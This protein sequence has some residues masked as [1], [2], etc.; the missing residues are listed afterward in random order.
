MGLIAPGA[1]ALVVA[2]TL[3]CGLASCGSSDDSQQR[4]DTREC[5]RLTFFH[6]G[7]ATEEHVARVGDV[8]RTSGG[9]SV[10]HRSPEEN[11]QVARERNEGP[12]TPDGRPLYETVTPEHTTGTWTADFGSRA[13]LDEALRRLG[14]AA[15]QTSMQP[16]D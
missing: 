13:Q 5:L 2:A 9:R 12:R 3:A 6:E 15:S 14:P 11:L 7:A 4:A 8:L 16:C 10:V 1:R